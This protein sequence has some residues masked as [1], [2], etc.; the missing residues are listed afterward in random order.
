MY[1]GLNDWVRYMVDKN[2]DH[3]KAIS[4]PVRPTNQSSGIAGTVRNKMPPS[5]A[6]LGKTNSGSPSSATGT[7]EASSPAPS[8]SRDSPSVS[9]R[10]ELLHQANAFGGKATQVSKGL[11]AKGKSRL[12]GVSSEKVD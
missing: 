4:A 12:R 7:S 3:A 10:Q 11:F 1:A 8:Q 6:K 2:P 5:I 9:K